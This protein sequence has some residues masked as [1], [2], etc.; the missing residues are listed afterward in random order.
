MCFCS[1]AYSRWWIDG[2]TMRIYSE[3][4]MLSIKTSQATKLPCRFTGCGC[5]QGWLK[6]CVYWDCSYSKWSQNHRMVWVGRL[7]IIY[8][9]PKGEWS[10]S[11]F[12]FWKFRRQLSPF[13]LT[14]DIP[15]LGGPVPTSTSGLLCHRLPP[16]L[17]PCVLLA[18]FTESAPDLT[19][20][21]NSRVGERA[22]S[23]SSWQRDSSSAVVSYGKGTTGG[24]PGQGSPDSIL[25]LTGTAQIF[26]T[27][28]ESQSQR[29]T[30]LLPCSELGRR[31]AEL[32]C[33]R[34]LFSHGTG[35]SCSELKWT[36]ASQRNG[37]WNR[38]NAFDL[39]SRRLL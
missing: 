35:S 20:E 2:C 24:E 4:I 28:G 34:S 23:L 12:W 7:N 27:E 39:N 10:P 30:I 14:L 37:L 1:C 5:W 26:W 22:N 36:T 17:P 19:Q 38:D 31:A 15:R 11:G 25:V 33:G 16:F 13:L 9:S 21:L 18:G 3:L 29:D 6:D 32:L 8:N